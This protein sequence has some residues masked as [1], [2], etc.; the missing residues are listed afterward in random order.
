MSSKRPFQVLEEFQPFAR[1]LAVFNPE[2]F[3]RADRNVV[4]RNVLRASSMFVPLATLMA[5]VIYNFWSFFD[6]ELVWS[7][8]AYHLASAFCSLQEFVIYTLMAMKNGQFFD[9]SEHLQQIVGKR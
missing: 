1:L 8:R 2:N 4:I 5:V 7:L 9:A 6:L 3:I